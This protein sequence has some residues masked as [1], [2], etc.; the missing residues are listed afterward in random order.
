MAIGLYLIP[1][2]IQ[3]AA[4]RNANFQM[5]ADIFGSLLH[6][7]VARKVVVVSLACKFMTKGLISNV[8]I[9]IGLIAGYIVPVFSGM[10]NFGGVENAKWF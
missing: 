8:A 5:A 4:G 1:V 10:V 9:L 6:W 2:A 3:Y 7:T